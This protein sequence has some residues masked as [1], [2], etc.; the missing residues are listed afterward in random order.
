MSDAGV[1]AARPR[2]GLGAV[3]GAVLIAA[4]T[5]QVVALSTTSEIRSGA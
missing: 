4:A 2:G 1:P 5:T 3:L